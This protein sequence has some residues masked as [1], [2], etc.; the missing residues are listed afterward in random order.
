MVSFTFLVKVFAG[1]QTMDGRIHLAYK[2]KHAVGPDI[3]A[4]VSA[5]FHN[6]GPGRATIVRKTS[7]SLRTDF[8]GVC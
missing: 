1:I 5:D 2:S 3:G 8:A 4:I 7:R 6:A